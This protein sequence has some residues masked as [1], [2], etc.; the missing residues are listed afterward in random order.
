MTSR[1]API[2]DDSSSPSRNH[3][4]S[5]V[6]LADNFPAKTHLLV[7]NITDIDPDILSFSPDGGS[8]FVFDQSAFAQKYLPQYFKH[9][10]YGSF[11]RQLNLY[12]FTSSRHKDNSEVVV[13]SHE[14]FHRDRKDLLKNI[15]RAVK[16]PTKK[17]TKPSHVHIAPRSAS[18]LS[19]SSEEVS[20]SPSHDC[21]DGPS[22]PFTRQ[23]S[24][25]GEEWLESEFAY[26]KQQNRHLEQKLDLLLKITLTLSPSSL[27]EFQL[28]EKRR[29]TFGGPSIPPHHQSYQNARRVLGTIREDH[30][31]PR[32]DGIE[33]MP[34][35]N[36]NIRPYKSAEVD[37]QESMKAFVDI[38]LSEEGKEECE[39][40]SGSDSDITNDDNVVLSAQGQ[41]VPNTAGDTYEDELMAE[42]MHA[43]LPNND[44]CDDDEFNLSFDENE[45]LPEHIPAPGAFLTVSNRVEDKSS[46][47]QPVLSTDS[48]DFRGDIEEGNTPVGV[49]IVSA[50]A[51]LVDDD[52][53][54]DD[55][56][57]EDR[58]SHRRKVVCILSFMFVVLLVTCV[59]VPT[60]I[61]K[62]N[63]NKSP[64]APTIILEG[65]RGGKGQY[66]VYKQKLSN[67]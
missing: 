51:E 52:S 44:F 1:S 10:N 4:T 28:G 37:N 53:R 39:A 31:V 24:S 35:R 21:D 23:V 50:H 25:K 27:E 30:R 7:S 40:N 16:K 66:H 2:V 46:G 54:K 32:N 33:P 45:A 22:E 5:T 41:H 62:Q 20:S 60:V 36:E 8:F 59:T 17:D 67:K 19:V 49:H 61:V 55:D 9:S 43:I 13:W 6:V 65:G 34:Y 58:R 56:S 14:F 64:P 47:P 15:K 42:A 26:L 29:R 18:A 3:G 11:V 38:M 63:R 57:F 48:Y 12:G